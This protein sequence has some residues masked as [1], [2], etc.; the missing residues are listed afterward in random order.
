MGL[1]NAF[2]LGLRL[3]GAVMAQHLKVKGIPSPTS[4]MA[5]AMNLLGPQ[6]TYRSFLSPHQAGRTHP[7]PNQTSGGCQCP[8]QG[9]K[10]FLCPCMACVSHLCH[11]WTHGSC[12]CPHKTYSHQLPVII[13]ASFA[14]DKVTDPIG[15][16]ASKSHRPCCHYRK[17]LAPLPPLPK[18]ADPA[19]NATE[20]FR[21]CCCCHCH[22]CCCQELPMPL[23]SWTE[24]VTWPCYVL[25]SLNA[26]TC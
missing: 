25:M 16:I 3:Q 24:S 21:P 1:K 17:S 26:L 22:C 15:S 23:D 19:A 14:A 13:S 9:H 4:P 6:L 10:E 18:A 12:L 11:P 7:P 20:N 2:L 8:C 5:W